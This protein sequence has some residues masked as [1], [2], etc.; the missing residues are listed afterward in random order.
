M[1]YKPNSSTPDYWFEKADQCFRR[2]RTDSKARVKLEALGNVFMVKAVKLD[3]KLRKL[4]KWQLQRLF[5]PDCG[6]AD[7]EMGLV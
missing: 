6:R 2:S 3:I 4:A 1:V 5:P 7:D